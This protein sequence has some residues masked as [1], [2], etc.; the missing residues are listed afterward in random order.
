MGNHS[1]QV[2][3]ADI[4]AHQREIEGH[5]IN[6]HLIIE[7]LLAHKRIDKS[8]L[9]TIVKNHLGTTIINLEWHPYFDL[10]KRLA[11]L[12]VLVRWG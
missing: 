11:D 5:M 6:F 9:G 10:G 1:I 2:S 8:A 3:T 12:F 4:V 7:A